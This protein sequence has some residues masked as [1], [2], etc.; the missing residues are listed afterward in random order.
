V[1][2]REAIQLGP[3]RTMQEDLAFGIRQLSDIALRA[4]SPAVNDPTTAYEVVVHLGA[5]LREL[6]LRD[7]PP[8]TISDQEGRWLVRPHEFTHAD[9]V[10]R[11]FDQIRQAGVSQTAVAITLLATL[12]M[13]TSEVQATDLADRA[14]PLQKQAHLIL[15]GCKAACPLPEDLE[16]VYAAAQKAGFQLYQQREESEDC[17]IE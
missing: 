1:L 17:M 16:Q 3:A 12:G 14:V 9:Y 10:N 8:I 2:L 5:I 13:L 6:L 7:L 11:A 15:A 4:L